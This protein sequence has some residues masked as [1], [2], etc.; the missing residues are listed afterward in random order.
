M[1]TRMLYIHALSPIHSGTGQSVDVIDLPV[2]REKVSNLPYLPGSSIKGVLRDACRPEDGAGAEARETY[3]DVFGP[4]RGSE[5]GNAGRLWFADGRLLCLPVRSLFGSLLWVTSP[6]VLRRWL[7]DGGS[8]SD[9]DPAVPV[10]ADEQIL[11]GAG[12]GASETV[13]HAGK[14]YLEDLELPVAERDAVSQL[15]ERIGA[16]VFDPTWQEVFRPR[17]GIVADDVFGFLAETGTEVTARI[18]IDNESKTVADGGLWYE[19]AV[20][21]ESIFACPLAAAPRS[22][23]D[24]LF[25]FVAAH[26]ERP[27]QIGGNASVGCGLARFQ[28]APGATS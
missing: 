12:A 6:F 11:V 3:I 19:E 7:R 10:P 8:G 21:A 26:L 18:R 17:F 27:L 16:A 5:G 23:A 1:T 13:G 2:A 20:P 9:S 15:G 22:P 4:E 28:L 25:A 24:T 14:A